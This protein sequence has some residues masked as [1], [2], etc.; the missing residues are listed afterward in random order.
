LGLQ[1]QAEEETLDKFMARIQEAYNSYIE[2]LNNG[3]DIQIILDK[4]AALDAAASYD[5]TDAAVIGGESDE[6]VRAT[7]E[8]EAT[9]NGLDA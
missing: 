9:K 7:M 3:E 4:Q 2:L 8:R 5:S 1:Q 6:A